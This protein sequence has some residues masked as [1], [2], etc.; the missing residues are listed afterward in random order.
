MHIF[1]STAALLLIDL[2]TL[3]F[4]FLMIRRP[5]ISTRTDTL[6][7]YATLFR[8]RFQKDELIW[9]RGQTFYGVQGIFSPG[10]I[11]ELEL[12]QLPEYELSVDKQTGQFRFETQADWIKS[13]WW[14]I[15]AMQL[16]NELRYRAIMH[17]YSRS[18][19][20]IMYARAKVK[21]AAKL[22]RLADV[23][24]ITV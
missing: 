24:G 9:L 5:P 10:F 4:F 20:D 21:L 22:A 13:T 2:F 23:D 7:P 1:C 16:V 19:L 17:N 14:E 11:H 3:M 6:F 12:L 15:H 8:S 18:E